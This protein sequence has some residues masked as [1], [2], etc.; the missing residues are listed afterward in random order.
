M[1]NFIFLILVALAAAF[2]G[3]YYGAPHAFPLLLEPANLDPGKRMEI[4]LAASGAAA[5]LA[6]GIVAALTSVWSMR[7]LVAGKRHLEMRRAEILSHLESSKSQHAAEIGARKNEFADQLEAKK[8]ELAAD[9]D[10]HKR[11]LGFDAAM[12]QLKSD[13][14]RASLTSI[15]AAAERYRQVISSLRFGVFDAEGTLASTREI[16][17]IAESTEIP[18]PIRDALVSLRRNGHRIA[19]RAASL[20]PSARLA[21]WAEKSGDG[22]ASSTLGNS[23]AA[24]ADQVLGM[25][26]E[27]KAKL[28]QG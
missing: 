27:T 20:E 17:R 4:L 15:G 13:T 18:E 11:K 5:L 22:A 23:F 16:D 28:L 9:L 25:I 2:A 3:V 6:A 14:A 19:E 7:G 1:S 24:D 8:N 10:D 26:A 21:L 12:H